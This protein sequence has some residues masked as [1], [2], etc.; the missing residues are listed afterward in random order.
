[1][2]P[3][4][5]IGESGDGQFIYM[6]GLLPLQDDLTV[7]VAKDCLLPALPK[8]LNVNNTEIVIPSL[9]NVWDQAG[10]TA[11]YGISNTYSRKDMTD[12]NVKFVDD[13]MVFKTAMNTKKKTGESFFTMV[14]SIST[15]MPY[16]SLI[17]SS[18]VLQNKTLSPQY[19]V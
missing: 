18:F 7:Q 13:E 1:M 12:E 19:L 2:Q 14:L 5:T 3:N 15:H 11:A 10:M 17:D 9:P 4:I 16:N 6:T 8:L